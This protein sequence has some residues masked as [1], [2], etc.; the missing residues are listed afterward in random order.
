[1]EPKDLLLSL[2]GIAMGSYSESVEASP[3]TVTYYFCNI[4]FNTTLLSTGRLS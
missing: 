4:H 2:Q 1:M 3:H